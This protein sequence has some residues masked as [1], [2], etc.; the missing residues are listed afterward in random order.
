M[1]F[2]GYKTN[3]I[4]HNFQWLW[5]NVPDPTLTPYPCCIPCWYLCQS[6]LGVL[7]ASC[8]SL[9]PEGLCGN[10]CP[11]SRHNQST[12]KCCYLFPPISSNVS[13][14]VKLYWPFLWPEM[15]DLNVSFKCFISH[16]SLCHGDETFIHCHAFLR[17]LIPTNASH[18]LPGSQCCSQSPGNNSWQRP[19]FWFHLLE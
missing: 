18:S 8:P 14:H 2:I 13:E 15:S 19:Y 12:Q 6:C 10:F 9:C 5:Q 1:A 11:Q 17:W 7:S 3:T 4:F 16:L